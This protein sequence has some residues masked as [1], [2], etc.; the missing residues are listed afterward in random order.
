MTDEEIRKVVTKVL[1][2][3]FKGLGLERVTVISENDFDGDPIIRVNARLRT[4]LAPAQRLVNAL[5]EIRSELIG[6][7]EDRFVFL[8]SAQPDEENVE[9]EVG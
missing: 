7:G 2:R 4:G 3:S 1:R 8:S 6:K 5:H 9:E